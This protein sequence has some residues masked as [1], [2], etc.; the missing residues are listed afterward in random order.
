MPHNEQPAVAD[1]DPKMGETSKGA[2]EQ[3]R[4]QV[5]RVV[6][7]DDELLSLIENAKYGEPSD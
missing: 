2:K 3:Q 7:I 4:I 1:S 6:D 5:I